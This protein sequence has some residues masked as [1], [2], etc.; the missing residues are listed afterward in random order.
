[1]R[2]SSYDNRTRNQGP[3]ATNRTG[4]AALP[5]R[6]MSPLRG[7]GSLPAAP[8]PATYVPSG[9]GAVRLRLSLLGFAVEVS[10]VPPD[11]HRLS[12][13]SLCRR[14]QF[15]SPTL[16]DRSKDFLGSQKSYRQAVR[17][18]HR[19]FVYDDRQEHPLAS[20]GAAL[21]HSTLWRWLSWL[22]SLTQTVQRA[23]QLI[24]HEDRDATL[25]SQVIAIDPRKHRSEERRMALERAARMLLVEAVF[26]EYFG[27]NLFPRFAT[28]C[29]WQ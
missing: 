26:G 23:S 1:M 19:S 10:E 12:A 7:R 22:G 24:C 20:R 21:A 2:S 4:A 3:H 29:G 5:R 11:I 18:Q 13:L 25:H 6:G 14:K 17:E 27:K 15:V 16:L 8:A 28:G 9:R